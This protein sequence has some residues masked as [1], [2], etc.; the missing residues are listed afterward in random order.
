MNYFTVEDLSG[1]SRDELAE[2]LIVSEED[3]ERAVERA[4]EAEKRVAEAL[5]TCK[6]LLLANSRLVEQMRVLNLYHNSMTKSLTEDLTET[7]SSSRS[8]P[9]SFLARLC[10]GSD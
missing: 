8:R 5:S 4:T 3:R 10:G 2:S 6:E 9:W 1:F 7:R